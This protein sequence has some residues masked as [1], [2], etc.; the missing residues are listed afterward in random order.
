MSMSRISMPLAGSTFAMSGVAFAP[1]DKPGAGGTVTRDFEAELKAMQ[2]KLDATQVERDAARGEVAEL[3]GALDKADE[4]LDE[5]SREAD[6]AKA[7][8]KAANEAVAKVENA[9]AFVDTKISNSKA[10]PVKDV[11]MFATERG[12][13]D[14]RIINAGEPFVF[15]GVPGMWMIPADDPKSADAVADA[16]VRNASAYQGA[17]KAI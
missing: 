16:K 14:G 17:A 7:E 10:D 13:Y 4:K 11:K 6:A 1:A 12:Y 3:T 15:S 5:L 9:V 2:A 8:A